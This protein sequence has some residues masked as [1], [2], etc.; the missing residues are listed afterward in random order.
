MAFHQA[1]Y[2]LNEFSSPSIR[3]NHNSAL[4]RDNGPVSSITPNGVKC[5]HT[6]VTKP[7]GSSVVVLLS[8]LILCVPLCSKTKGSC[9]SYV[10]T[11]HTSD[12]GKGRG[13]PALANNSA[14]RPQSSKKG[15]SAAPNQPQKKHRVSLYYTKHKSSL[16]AA[17]AGAPVDEEHEELSPDP[18]LTPDP[19]VCNNNE[20]AFVSELD[21]KPP[22]DPK[23]EP[24]GPTEEAPAAVMFPMEMP[25]G[26]PD[27][28]T[29]SPGPR[30]GLLVCSPVE[31]SRPQLYLDKMDTDKRDSSETE[32]RKTS[33]RLTLCYLTS[34]NFQFQLCFYFLLQL[35]EDGKGQK[36]K[37]LSAECGAASGNNKGKRSR[38][39]AENTSRY[40][41]LSIL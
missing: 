36:K 41:S 9:K 14:P 10:D 28:V 7:V 39:K 15:S 31:K 11:C 35:R 20:P 22:A 24:Q 1:Q 19:D 34:Q 23:E 38:R 26:F 18:C 4:P 12:K 21:K 25:A 3:S 6:L 16:S 33:Y 2:I 5:V 17:A 32:V 29:L 40:T 30:P 13:S 37:A 27:N 8:S